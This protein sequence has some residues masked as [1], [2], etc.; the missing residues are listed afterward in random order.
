[1]ELP[2]IPTQYRHWKGVVGR[3]VMRWLTIQQALCVKHTEAFSGGK[4]VFCASLQHMVVI[5]ADLL[6]Q[7]IPSVAF[8]LSN[9][10]LMKMKLSM[11]P[12]LIT[13]LQF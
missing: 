12:N 5:I 2:K 13:C 11:M 7:S 4:S 6:S 3:G 8:L 1:M 10:N 9:N